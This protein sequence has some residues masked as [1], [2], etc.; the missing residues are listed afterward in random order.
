MPRFAEG[1]EDVRPGDEI[2]VGIALTNFG[3]TEAEITLAALTSDGILVSGED[4]DNPGSLLL[5]TL[6]QYA[7]LDT[8][9][10]GFGLERSAPKGWIELTSSSSEVGGF[11]TIF[12]SKLSFMDATSLG[13][14]PLT[15]LILPE[16][17]ANGHTK[18]DIVNGNT[19]EAEVKIDLMSADGA[20]RSSLTRIIEGKGALVAEAYG[21]LFRDIEP[22]SKDYVRISS[23]RG[24]HAFQLMQKDA[25]DNYSLGGLDMSEGSTVL[26]APHYVQGG[27]YQTALSLI[28]LESSAGTVALQFVGED[29]V[30]I[31]EA[32]TAEIPANGK[33]YIDDPKYFGSLELEVLNC[34]YVKVTS[35]V[36]LTGSTVFGDRN[37]AS[38]A[39]ALPLIHSPRNSVLYSLVA[40]N[41]QYFTGLAIV[42]PGTGGANAAVQLYSSAGELLDETIIY[43][44]AG[45]RKTKLLTEFFPSIEGLDLTSGYFQVLSDSPLA[46]FAL[47][48]TTSLSALSAIP[49]VGIQTIPSPLPGRAL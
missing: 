4:I 41:D 30:Q 43:L 8:E 49:A 48:G 35:E 21:D 24:L 42:N 5:S 31:G 23:A 27:S 37:N 44:P 29:G 34:G 39:A 20:V 38:F 33:L 10:F 6:Q 28:N 7:R 11:F 40:S 32:R 45:Q 18:I 36:R 25:G 17:E 15:N 12:D 1:Q 13:N 3:E 26:Y 46:S 14:A 16:I 2:A 22:Q 19:D 9:I 47:F